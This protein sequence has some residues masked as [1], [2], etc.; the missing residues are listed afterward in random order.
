[1]NGNVGSLVRLVAHTKR[2]WFKWL[3]RRSQRNRLN[4]E[5]FE[6]LY[7]DAA[8][9][10]SSVPRIPPAGPALRLRRE[11][12]L[13][14]PSALRRSLHDPRS[15]DGVETGKFLLQ[16][17]AASSF[18]LSLVGFVTVL[19]VDGCHSCHSLDDLSERCKSLV[20]KRQIIP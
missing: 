15:L 18:D 10:R 5:R 17:H 13:T 9:A 6:N 16:I 19:A 11:R 7:R 2:A 1:M 12:S 8:L 4:W 20:V 14:Q 3:N